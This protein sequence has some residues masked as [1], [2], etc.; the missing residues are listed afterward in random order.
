[1]VMVRQAYSFTLLDWAGD[2]QHSTRAPCCCHTSP[3]TASHR[4]IPSQANLAPTVRISRNIS[5]TWGEGGVDDSPGSRLANI[6]PKK[7]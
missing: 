3:P 2:V 6:C 1:M 4:M 5:H 7:L